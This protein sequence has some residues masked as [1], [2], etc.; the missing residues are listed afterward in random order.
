LDPS[1]FQHGFLFYDFQ[2]ETPTEAQ[3]TLPPFELFRDQAITIGLSSSKSL[4]SKISSQYLRELRN[5]YP[6]SLIHRIVSIDESH[7]QNL[8]DVLSLPA[9]ST[10]QNITQVLCKLSVILL[11]E[12]SSYV[13]SVQALQTVASPSVTTRQLVQ[14]PSW[15]S[16]RPP[17][18]LSDNQPISPSPLSKEMHR[19]SMPI[20]AT[21]P[22]ASS[23]TLSVGSPGFSKPP[24]KTFE[25]MSVNNNAPTSLSMDRF[26]N[27]PTSMLSRE[28]SR[29]KVPVHGFGSESFSERT[30]D[31]GKARVGVIVASVYL[32]AG[33]WPQALSTAV[34]SASK[35]RWYSDHIWHGRALEIISIC[36]VLLSW[37]D[38]QYQIPQVFQAHSNINTMVKHDAASQY[39][40]DIKPFPDEEVKGKFLRSLS[41]TLPT[42]MNMIITI[43]D[44]AAHMTT[45]DLI[46]QLVLSEFHIRVSKL[47]SAIHLSGGFFTES[48]LAN[49]VLGTPLEVSPNYY[50]TGVKIRPTKQEISNILA[51]ADPFLRNTDELDTIDVATILT[52]IASVFKSLGMNRK[53]ALVLKEMV[54]YIIPAL[55]QAQILGAAEA[56]LHPSTN[57]NRLKSSFSDSSDYA[58]VEAFL[59]SLCQIHGISSV[60]L[61]H[62]TVSPTS[63]L[64]NTMVL[65][66]GFQPGSLE[67]KADILN[68]CVKLCETLSDHRGI[69]H[70][71]TALLRTMGPS[72]AVN[73]DSADRTPALS[74][75]EQSQI[76]NKINVTVSELKNSGRSDTE[77]HYWDD[78]LVR[79]LWLME[80]PT[81][82]TL[83]PHKQADLKIDE[84]K[85]KDPFLHNPFIETPAVQ[86]WRNLL[87]ADSERE[88]VV[89]L[90]N[91][92]E[93][94]VE[95]EYAKLVAGDQDLGI[96]KTNFTLKPLRTQNI[97]IP[98]SIKEA[99]EIEITGCVVKIHGC[100]EQFFSVYTD[101]WTPAENVKLKNTRSSNHPTLVRHSAST[102]GSTDLDGVPLLPKS[103]SLPLIVIPPQ[104]TLAITSVSVPED[105]I[106]LLEGE[107][108]TVSITLTNISSI[109]ADFV[110]VSFN[111]SVSAS[112]QSR[113]SQK[114][115]SPADMYEMEYQMTKMTSIT[116]KGTFP[117]E[118]GPGESATYEFIVLAKWGLSTAGFHFDYASLKNSH[119]QSAETFF[120]RQV[121]YNL[122]ITVNPSLQITRL[123]ILPSP[124]LSGPEASVEDK[125]CLLMIDL[126]NGWPGPLTCCLKSSTSDGEM[127][128]SSTIIK[129]MQI[130]RHVLSM[131]KIYLTNPYQRITPMSTSRK[132]QFV[133]S[134]EKIIPEIER[135]NREAFWFRQK[136]LDTISG[137]WEVVEDIK[138]RH[139]TIIDLRRIEIQPPMLEA[140][141]LPDITLDFSLQSQGRDEQK[142]AVFSVSIDEF[143][144][145]TV[146]LSNR[147]PRII[148][149][150]LRIRPH[151]A[152]Q[153]REISLDLSKRLAWSGVLQQAVDALL[154]SSS[155]SFHFSL[156]ALAAGK[157]EISVNV[158]ETRVSEAIGSETDKTEEVLDDLAKTVDKRVWIVGKSCALIVSDQ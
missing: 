108:I 135:A 116:T 65:P 71:C 70:Y 35:A 113:L 19:M 38:F 16:D 72:V 26:K 47:L 49:I 33:L 17:S 130:Y 30:R 75:E 4:D 106:M 44:R 103:A 82:S 41:F 7:D 149:P 100:K 129:P 136:L 123:E 115:I 22:T 155:S 55:S 153:P 61:T 154:P 157:Y 92:F 12:W 146:I 73:A 105:A 127:S 40:A 118:I 14:S 122:S 124:V 77:A 10:P 104:P 56:G 137:T 58:G 145:L 39:D 74:S 101:S 91:P 147:T 79:G 143:L 57:L 142:G 29:D 133:V 54:S 125:N 42:S 36:M 140:L 102:M 128:T 37:A 150:L 121:K 85:D 25:E 24:A 119:L 69:L 60:P 93:F 48:S 31:K 89:L 141:R 28:D 99:G 63:S 117:T 34:E 76:F 62:T 152:D 68:L 9:R 90:Q 80:A 110:H 148:Y 11:E 43:Y 53:G 158:E 5:H 66:N 94:A 8:Q 131:P 67:M 1:L 18:I 52:G 32:H 46:P 51:A 109:S 21:T 138:H 120:T 88:F 15:L 3:Q 45:G 139:G 23:D 134:S 27:R 13:V 20:I 83:R 95:V 50:L 98:G 151:L 78:F 126:R 81:Q 59:A 87:S 112:N 156:C 107:E 2:Y 97:S 86:Q 132:R 144:T 64:S 84:K 96:L 114:G 111:D 6:K